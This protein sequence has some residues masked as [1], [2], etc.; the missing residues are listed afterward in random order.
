MPSLKMLGRSLTTGSRRRGES[1]SLL[2][3]VIIY[4]ARL[5]SSSVAEVVNIGTELIRPLAAKFNL[6]FTSFG[7]VI[8]DPSAPSSG[9]VTLFNHSTR[10]EPAPISPYKDSVAFDILSGTIKS[11]YN[12]HRGL[13]GKDNI[14]VYPAYMSGNTG[15]TERRFRLSADSRA[16]I[17]TRHYWKLSENIYRYGH[18]NGLKMEGILGGVHTVNESM[19]ISLFLKLLWLTCSDCR[20]RRG[21]FLGD[22]RVLCGPHSQR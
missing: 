15:R 8:T 7:E 11:V 17:D 10:L 5:S 21:R 22:D 16:S 9:S 20:S 4:S 12:A 2:L 18:G 14:E 3:L 1:F 6:S 13:E 19:L